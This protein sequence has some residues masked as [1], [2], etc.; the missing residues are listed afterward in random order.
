MFFI[1]YYCNYYDYYDYYDYCNY[2][3][4]YNYSDYYHYYEVL[5]QDNLRSSIICCLFS[6]E[7]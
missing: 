7:I 3:D 4:Y 5:I 6:G 2:Y 1:Y